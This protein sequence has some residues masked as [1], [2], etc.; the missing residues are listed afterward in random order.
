MNLLMIVLSYFLFMISQTPFG[1]SQ[2]LPLSFFL[3]SFLQNSSYH[4]LGSYFSHLISMDP[5]LSS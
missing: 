2:W 3:F 1:H 4:I 5:S